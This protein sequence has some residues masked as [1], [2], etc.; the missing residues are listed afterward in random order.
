MRRIRWN[1]VT[2]S[3][4]LLASARGGV[5]RERGAWT[6]WRLLNGP[7]DGPPMRRRVD[8]KRW[9]ECALAKGAP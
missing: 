3:C 6:P 8:A 4:V 9:V 2:A 7:V 5:F 1:Y